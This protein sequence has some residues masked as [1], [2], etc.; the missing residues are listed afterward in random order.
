MQ[1]RG[2]GTQ[3]LLWTE[4]G[5]SGSSPPDWE[6]NEEGAEEEA[7]GGGVRSEMDSHAD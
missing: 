3:L 7:H 4:L 6:K 5:P 1:A 2:A